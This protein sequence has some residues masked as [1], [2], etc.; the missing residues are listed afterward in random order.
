[1]INIRLLFRTARR[2]RRDGFTLVELLVVIGIIAILAGV[3]LGPITGGIEKA[4]ENAGMQA[5]RSINLLC[6]SYSNDNNQ[7]YLPGGNSSSATP[8][9][10][11]SEGIASALLNN[12]Y[13]S[14]ATIFAISSAHKYTGSA[15]PYSLA[16]GNV[17]FDFVAGSSTSVGLTATA[18]DQTPIVF[19]D[20]GVAGSVVGPSGSTAGYISGLAA[21]TPFGQNG[22][23]V[24]YKSNS[25]Q[26]LKATIVGSGT[27][28]NNFIST[29]FSDTWA[30]SN[31]N[32]IKP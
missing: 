18:P 6:F 28:V 22:V 9:T 30:T 14:D 16:S 29:S 15:A 8:A 10:S 17:D 13:A 5:A 21:S 25:A 11:T 32:V 3:A 27:Q 20:I 1:M 23:A 19:S 26:F 24:A 2:L 7:T 31:Y 4:K 12:K